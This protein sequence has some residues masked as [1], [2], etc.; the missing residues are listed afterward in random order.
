MIKILIGNIK[1]EIKCISAD[2]LEMFQRS[3]RKEIVMTAA[4]FILGIIVTLTYG[5]LT[6]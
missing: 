2:L 4:A 1:R 5:G 3:D 6:L